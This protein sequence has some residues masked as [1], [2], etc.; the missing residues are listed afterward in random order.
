MKRYVIKVKDC[1]KN[2]HTGLFT[3][4]EIKKVLKDIGPQRFSSVVSDGA[5][6]MQLAKRLISEEY[7]KIL[8]VHHMQLICTDIMKKN[9][10]SNNILINYQKFVTYFAESHQS[11]ATL[12]VEIKKELIVG[13]GLKRSVKTRW[14][15]AWDCC[16]SVLHLETIFK[17]VSE[18]VV[19]F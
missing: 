7:P 17:N 13:G 9:P 18:I 14:S 3:A 10:F 11:E 12:H 2:S 1:S 8:P 5:S 15:I 19:N 6:A 4:E 16:T